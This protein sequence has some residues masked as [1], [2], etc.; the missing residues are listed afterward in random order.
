MPR[1]IGRAASKGSVS[2]NH[3]CVEAIRPEP[4]RHVWHRES[5]RNWSGSGRDQIEL[6]KV[7]PI[8]GCIA[9]EKPVARDRSVGADV[10]VG[11]R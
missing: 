6:G 9:R 7:G 11:Q 4:Q 1:L 2:L 5:P 3:P 8:T 10:E